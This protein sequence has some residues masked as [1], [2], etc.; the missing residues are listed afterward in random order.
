[1][2]AKEIIDSVHNLTLSQQKYVAKWLIW[3]IDKVEHREAAD[4]RYKAIIA[5]AEEVTNMRNDPKRKDNDSVFVRTLT[6][7]RM[8]DEGYT[9]K[10]IAS[11]MKKDHSTVAYISSIRKAAKQLP[12]AYRAYL[13]S[14]DKLQNALKNDR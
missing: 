11:A 7:W 4:E 3:H 14:F 1:M 9:Q 2:D 10:D 5:V 8:M 13:Y 6:A 12:N